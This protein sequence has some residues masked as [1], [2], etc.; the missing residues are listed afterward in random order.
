M[1]KAAVSHVMATG[2]RVSRSPEIQI[3]LNS[4]ADMDVHNTLS[5]S[6]HR[7]RTHTHTNSLPPLSLSL[8][9]GERKRRTLKQ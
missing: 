6:L 3:C 4:Y 8:S 7:P 9:L 1:Q 2:Y 5:S